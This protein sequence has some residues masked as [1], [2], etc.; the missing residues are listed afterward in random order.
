[1]MFIVFMRARR[2]FAVTPP[3]PNQFRFLLDDQEPAVLELV[4]KRHHA[5]DQRPLR[6]EAAG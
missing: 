2:S 3:L 1:M 4:A 6:F 5:T